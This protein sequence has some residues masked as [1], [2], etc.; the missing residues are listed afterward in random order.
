MDDFL[1][2]AI[3]FVG[4]LLAA[5]SS[6]AKKKQHDD[7]G[8]GKLP[9]RPMSELQRAFMMM[10][11]PESE[12]GK[13]KEN[14]VTPRFT[15]QKVSRLFGDPGF[16][17]ARPPAGTASAREF[18]SEGRGNYEG[19]GESEGSGNFEG[20]SDYGSVPHGSITGNSLIEE[21]IRVQRY[22]DMVSDSAD[23][24]FESG[25]PSLEHRAEIEYRLDES[26]QMS[27]LAE[28]SSMFTETV[29]PRPRLKL[30]EDKNDLVKAVIFSE[31]LARRSPFSRTA[32]RY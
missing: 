19:T 27:D 13:R 22:R 17:A 25:G 15:P 16:N 9:R 32:K 20:L 6:A 24:A 18:T 28:S 1:V 21:E 10:S 31:V 26:A 11:G 29:K 2:I 3:I 30:F 12:A 4:A 8:E 23:S 5:F 7:D 14:T